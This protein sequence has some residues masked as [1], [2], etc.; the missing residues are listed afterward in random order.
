MSR[1][2][3]V[4]GAIGA[5]AAGATLIAFIQNPAPAPP[6]APV[7]RGGTFVVPV[8][9]R[10]IDSK[11][12][13]VTGLTEKDFTVLEDGKPQEIRQFSAVTLTADPAPQPLL[14]AQRSATPT[15]QNRRIFL[16][17]LGSEAHDQGFGTMTDVAAFVRTRLLPQDQVA[18]FA[19][20]RATDFT[21]DREM[22]ATI[23]GRYAARS[24]QIEFALIGAQPPYVPA[25]YGYREVPSKVQA[26]IDWI[27]DVPG[28][29][30]ARLLPYASIPGQEQMARDA[31]LAWATDNMATDHET[32][33]DLSNLY[34]GIEYLRNIDG[35]KHLLFVVG[36]LLNL[37]RFEDDGNLVTVAADARVA[38]HN[39]QTRGLPAGGT[40]VGS[41]LTVQAARFVSEQTGGLT[42]V[43]SYAREGLTHIADATE[44][45]YLLGYAPSN[46]TWDGRYRR[47]TVKVNR[48]GVK[49]LY[50]HGYFGRQELTPFDR[51]AALTYTRMAGAT[52]IPGAVHD[53]KV[54]LEAKATHDQAGWALDLQVRVN[55]TPL[56]WTSSGE[57]RT[58]EI[59]V[60]VFCAG[61]DGKSLGELL[62]R[63]NIRLSP[64][65]FERAKSVGVSYTVRIRLA[66][67]PKRL[68][69]VVYDFAADLVGTASQQIR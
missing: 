11:G 57:D 21:T 58:A 63:A 15:A 65:Q 45:G 25:S 69:V 55:P 3:F 7:F 19:F 32:I 9:V 26:D 53:I 29:A 10:V 54:D 24:R 22:V 68:R 64:E 67:A 48:S 38:I 12:R 40:T 31:L 23:L 46:G 36:Q 37:P 13:P 59:D 43:F 35:E 33:E 4:I 56:T 34:R 50:R 28:A 41:V 16:I 62:R 66:K 51:R 27:F 49:L 1:W 20:N 44:T 8:D 30:K 52:N 2:P 18:V 47:I 17:V 61:Q 60:G 6:Q 5:C 14:R 39:I 42:S